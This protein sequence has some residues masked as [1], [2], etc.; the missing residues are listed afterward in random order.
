MNECVALTSD[1]SKIAGTARPFLKWAGGK[2]WLANTLVER[3][4]DDINRYYEPFIGGGSVFFRL[5]PKKATLSDSNLSLIQTYEVV[6]DYPKRVLKRLNELQETHSEEQYY[7]MRDSNFTNRLEAAVRFLYLNRTCWNGLYRVNKLGKFNVPIGTK[8]SVVMPS[9]DFDA[10]SA[11]LSSVSLRCCD[12][13]E[14]IGRAKAGDFIYCDPPYTVKH[15]NNGFLKYNEEIF[16]W[17]DQVRLA[18]ALTRADLRGV[19]FAVS[20]AAHESI[21]ELYSGFSIENLQRASVISG[22]ARGRGL[23]SELLVTNF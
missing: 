7:R 23:Y 9:D 19:R 4:P 13:A 2:R 3:F 15:N 11:A 10:I 20:N 16:S 5:R 22:Q 12:F 1:V 8:T 18:Q 6:R 21:L 17:C 14:A